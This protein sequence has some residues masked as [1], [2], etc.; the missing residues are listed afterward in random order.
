MDESTPGKSII[1][2][3]VSSEDNGYLANIQ[4]AIPRTTQIL[5]HRKMSSSEENAKSTTGKSSSP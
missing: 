3:S 2:E 1:I 4:A 5:S